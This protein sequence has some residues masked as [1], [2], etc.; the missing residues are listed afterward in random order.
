[1]IFELRRGRRAGGEERDEAR[2]NQDK[3]VGAQA[4]P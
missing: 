4:K 3:G 1:M 2:T